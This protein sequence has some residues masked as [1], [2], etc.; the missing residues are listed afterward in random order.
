MLQTGAK[1]RRPADG[2]PA[3]APDPCPAPSPPRA[4]VRSLQKDLDF[5]AADEG[6][7][8]DGRSFKRRLARLRSLDAAF[9][10]DSLRDADQYLREYLLAVRA[11]QPKLR[12]GERGAARGFVGPVRAELRTI[13]VDWVFEVGSAL[14]LMR[15]TCHLAVDLIDRYLCANADSQDCR[16]RLQ[17]LGVTAL[18]MASK[19][20]EIYPP[21][22]KAF[23]AST[24]G[25]CGVEAIWAFEL[26]VLQ[27][28]DWR[29]D[30]PSVLD[31]T[32]AKCTM[33]TVALSAEGA[34]AVAPTFAE[35][36]FTRAMQVLDLAAHDCRSV[37]LPPWA[38][39]EAAFK[40]LLP[41]ETEAFREEHQRAL[42]GDAA[43][44]AP[45]DR[46]RALALLG[47]IAGGLDLTLEA[48]PPP[49]E[50]QRRR[51]WGR[52]YVQKHFR[53]TLAWVKGKQAAA[54]RAEA[55]EALRS[56]ETL[57]EEDLAL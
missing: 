11:Q 12:G 16:R 17:L 7:P 40:L 1:R 9:P 31:A 21:S 20:E 46:D 54:L 38:L 18:H 24:Q 32:A 48:P 53:E 8:A 28:L 55:E 50:S 27:A 26:R 22:G 34:P 41:P 43:A 39:S 4:I 2:G 14:Q 30:V 36:L 3:P 10:P 49:P 52:R 6:G 56:E 47:D 33:L 51:D 13:L 35:A 5:A 19:V 44:A 29:V 37:P 23:A 45:E 25:S 42:L 15:R 57:E